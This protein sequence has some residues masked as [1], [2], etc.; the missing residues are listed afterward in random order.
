MPG[1]RFKIPCELDKAYAV[2]IQ[3]DGRVAY[4]YLE[5]FEDA[6]ADVWLY[7]HVE[8]PATGFW[9]DAGQPALNPAE[10]INKEIRISPIT[11]PDEI[12]C[13]WTETSDGMIEVDI[14]LRGKFIAQLIPGA[15]P[16][17]SALV[18]KDGPLALVY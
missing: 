17:W 8:A 9:T 11:N 5:M 10:Y 6:V 4:A 14:L 18:V 15:K 3:D 2:V 13:E 12:R 16:G 1:I 7:N